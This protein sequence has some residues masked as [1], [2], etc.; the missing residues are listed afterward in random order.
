MKD[1]DPQGTDTLIQRGVAR[2]AKR[3]RTACRMFAVK[4]RRE[5]SQSAGG[6][7]GGVLE[8]L[9][10]AAFD[11][12]GAT[13]DLQTDEALAQVGAGSLVYFLAVHNNR[14]TVLITDAGE[15]VPL[16]DG[17]FLAFAGT[18]DAVAAYRARILVLEFSAVLNRGAVPE[19]EVALAVVHALALDALRPD[20]VG[21]CHVDDHSG[22]TGLGEAPL[23]REAILFI[24]L[25]S[26]QEAVR[27]TGADEEVIL[28]APGLLGGR[29]GKNDPT[30]GVFAVEEFGFGRGRDRVVG[31]DMGDSRQQKSGDEGNAYEMHGPTYA[32]VHVS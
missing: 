28:Y 14:D 24:A 8:G 18:A 3:D 15:G 5:A 29:F 2:H 16:A 7:A 9:E 19:I 11:L 21:R 10:G 32:F 12:E 30:G 23:D 25:L 31:G 6:Y 13:F 4:Q 1:R 27:L 17:L 22:I 26:A 20:G